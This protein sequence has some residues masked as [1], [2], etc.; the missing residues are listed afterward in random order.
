MKTTNIFYRALC[1]VLMAL[2][3]VMASGQTL[4]YD[5]EFPQYAPQSPTAYAFA[6]YVDYPYMKSRW[7]ALTSPFH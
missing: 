1:L 4:E 7:E 6:K 5:A 2:C 3:S